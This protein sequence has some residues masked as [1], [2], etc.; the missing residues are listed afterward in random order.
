MPQPPLPLP[1]VAG[2]IVEP[3]PQPLPLPVVAGYIVVDD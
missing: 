3:P 1:V 2:Y